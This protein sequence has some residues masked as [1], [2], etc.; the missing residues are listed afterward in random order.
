MA[1]TSRPQADEG[2]PIVELRIQLDD[3][4]ELFDLVNSFAGL[5]NQFQAHIKERHPDIQSDAKI[6]VNDIRAGSIIVEL[7]P[8]IQSFIQPMGM[9][10]TVD[11]FVIRLGEIIHGFANGQKLEG[12]NKKDMRDFLGVVETIAKDPNAILSV[13]SAEYH[14]TKTTKRARFEF[15]TKDAKAA[16][17]VIVEQK[18]M[19]E[20]PAHEVFTN[21][22]MVFWQSNR[23]H[24][25]VGRR[26]GERAIIEQLS[27]KDLAVTYETDLARERIKYETIQGDQNLFK[28]GFF[29]DGYV[30]RLNNRPVAYRI[31]KLND[32]ID[33]PDDEEFEES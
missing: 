17:D 18:N 25:A 13:E 11:Q 28:L 31:T 2:V 1:D 20:L 16:R 26:T 14:E 8:V 4:P 33:L 22:L 23:R 15:N 10:V 27:K 12:A 5:A 30:E 6:C 19:L 24:T 32:V 29:V 21:A 3:K 7:M 9:L